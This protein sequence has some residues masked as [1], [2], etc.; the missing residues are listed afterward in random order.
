[1]FVVVECQA[2][3]STLS[4]HS[5]V[6]GRAFGIQIKN[7]WIHAIF[8]VSHPL[9]CSHS[10]N[11]QLKL[12]SLHDSR[13]V[14]PEEVAIKQRLKD[15]RR[16]RNVVNL[17]LRFGN[18]AVDPVGDVQGAV[19]AEGEDVVGGDGLGLT[20][21]LEHEEL[22]KNGD[23]LEPDGEGPHDLPEVI[24][25]GQEDGECG[26]ESKQVLDLEGVE[27]GIVGGLVGTDHEVD[28]VTGGSDEEDLEDDVVVACCPEE[29]EIAG[30]IYDEVD[31]LRLERDPGAT[32]QLR[33]L[34]EKNE[35]RSQV[36][37]VRGNAEDVERHGCELVVDVPL[38]RRAS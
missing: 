2:Q 17:M 12:L 22:R 15:T 25:V 1:M 36:A 13:I 16:H 5:S 4:K 11:G 6:D 29:V 33:H 10:L 26:G 21:T 30:D 24:L 8:L 19:D 23:R 38:W 28:D 27:P 14:N 3:L 34:M 35:D 31:D 7:G 37:K 32:L 20:G 18:V 9:T